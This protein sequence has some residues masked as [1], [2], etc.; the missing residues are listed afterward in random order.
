MSSPFDYPLGAHRPMTQDSREASSSDQKPVEPPRRRI[1]TFKS[2]GNPDF[3]L[4]WIGNIFNNIAMW[5]Q[6]ISLGFLVWEITDG[7]AILSG[8]IGGLRFL[9]TILIGP[10]AGVLADRMDR[11]RLVMGTQMFLAACALLFA[12]WVLWIGVDI[13]S[14]KHVEVW[15]AYLYASV[16]AIGHG[17]LQPARQALIANTVP[18]E[19]LGN[20]YALNSMTVTSARL[21]GGIVGG[22]LIGAVGFKFNF[23]V[24]AAL[25]AMMVVLLVPMRARYGEES[26]ARRSSVMGNLRDGLGYVWNENRV[27]LH[28]I[29]MNFVL[30]FAFRPIQSLLPAYTGEVLNLEEGAREGGFL[31]AAQGV[32]GMLGALVLAGI[33]FSLNKGQLSLIVLIIGSTAM[34]AFG[35]SHWLYLSLPMMTVM[36]FCQTSFITSN[37]TLVQTMTPDQLR[38]RVTSIYMLE[39]GLGPLA[40]LIISVLIEYVGAG[41]ALTGVAAG[42]LGLAIYFQLAFKQVRQLK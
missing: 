24:E 18:R 19:N 25:L 16:S 8:V 35:Q 6:L 1:Q 31:L 3:R 9:P 2:L 13:E 29:L 33:G 32:G 21:M 14:G 41:A 20:A 37:M 28:L 38:G 17:F 39:S 34:I 23:F 40:I 10:W 22:V 5:L 30:V 7:S 11:R 27:I 15:H 4:F 42:S 36:G 12:L 26:T